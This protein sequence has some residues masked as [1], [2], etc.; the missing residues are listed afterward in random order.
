MEKRLTFVLSASPYSG[1]TAATALKLATAALAAGHRATIFATADGVYGF[2][3][4][5][6]ATAV[7]D[8]GGA[9]AAFLAR[10]GAVDL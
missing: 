5:Q 10:G 2:V 3:K 6:Q 9:A 1:Q 4:G 7:F 8:V